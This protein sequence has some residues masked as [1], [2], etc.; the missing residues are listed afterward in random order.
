[1]KKVWIIPL[2]LLFI[3]V[4]A[5]T[6]AQAAVVMT[7]GND[8]QGNFSDAMAV[9]S[10]PNTNY[11]SS[12]NLY[13]DFIDGS[14]LYV[15]LQYFNVTNILG[16]S[17][18]QSNNITNC[19]VIYYKYSDFGSDTSNMTF[20][21][22]NTSWDEG[23]VTW[24]SYNMQN[25]DNDYFANANVRSL[26]YSYDTSDFVSSGSHKIDIK[27][28]VCQSWGEDDAINFGFSAQG[29]YN[30]AGEIGF[31]FRSREY[32]T[33]TLERWGV[34]IT[35]ESTATSAPVIDWTNENLP[36]NY[37]I[38]VTSD[39]Y[40]SF[41]CSDEDSA[42]LSA[43][44]DIDGTFKQSVYGFSQGQNQTL[45]F[46]SG[47]LSEG[48]HTV[49]LTCDDGSDNTTASKNL[50]WDTTPPSLH[51]ESGFP[52]LDNSSIAWNTGNVPMNIT[53]SDD[54]E[55]WS[56]QINITN[57]TGDQI[58]SFYVE[59]LNVS[60]YSYDSSVYG[61]LDLSSNS[62]GTVYTR[63]E[64]WDSHTHKTIKDFKPK[65]HLDTALLEYNTGDN[66]I[67]VYPT[68]K[69]DLTSFG[70]TKKSDRYTFDYEF[71]K[72]K[73]S[74]S[75]ILSSWKPITYQK[76]SKYKGHFVTGTDWVD[77]ELEQATGKE[78]YTITRLDE[79]TY[80]VTV[81]TNKKSLKF[82]SVGKLNQKVE[83]AQFRLGSSPPT[84]PTTQTPA[85]NSNV[86]TG[87]QTITC[88]GSTD[89]DGDT[90]YVQF[91]GDE[92]NDNPS[93]LLQNTTSTSYA[94]S[95][96]PLASYYWKCRAC[97]VNGGCS[98]YTEIIGFNNNNQNIYN[99]TQDGPGTA[100]EGETT[101]FGL[102]FTYNTQRYSAV[103]TKL[104]MGGQNYTA[105][106]GTNLDLTTNYVNAPIAEVSQNTTVEALWFIELTYLNGSKR[107]DTSLGYNISVSNI[108]FSEGCT[109]NTTDALAINFSF[110]DENNLAEF[111]YGANDSKVDLDA[112]FTVYKDNININDTRSF[113]LTNI[114][115][116]QLCIPQGLEL[117]TRGQID[118]V[119]DD[120]DKR[121]FFYYDKT[122][123]NQT[124]N[125]SLYLLE[126]SLATGITFVI[127][128][129]SGTEIADAYIYVDRYD[130][131]TDTYKLVAMGLT[132]EDGEDYIFL[133]KFDVEYRVRIEEA[134][135]Q[136]YIDPNNR[137]ISSSDNTVRIRTSEA[138]LSGVI[139]QFKTISYTLVNDT[140]N[141]IFTY[142]DSSSSASEYCLTVYKANSTNDGFICET[143]LTTNT[144]TITCDISDYDG[145]YIATAWVSINP[146][147]P[148]AQIVIDRIDS[149]WSDTD[150]GKT[151]LFG[152]FLIILTLGCIGAWMGKVSTTI[153]MTLLGVFLC[154]M[155]G[156]MTFG[157][158]NTYVFMGLLACGLALIF[159]SRS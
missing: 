50:Y 149:I 86:T 71:S 52:L 118:Y 131:G 156:F 34:R 108:Y 6:S 106:T 66:V 138:T 62:N 98:A 45:N 99:V 74:Y 145:T 112:T 142:S 135:V 151:G 67:T 92:N 3:F 26:M 10:S 158:A 155:L 2:M 154:M 95:M 18:L 24:N 23:T 148:I 17:I 130:T 11:G 150:F 113:S 19:T 103:T 58:H 140:T 56:F 83:D 133:R 144:G 78:K 125:E 8:T 12:T 88:T 100:I 14:T 124:Q 43:H 35:Y 64:C 79:Y 89:P 90:I 82:K 91:V 141:V 81:K 93:T 117:T 69:K 102:N 75:F 104:N 30:P 84:I 36:N 80:L 115:D 111:T 63:M 40:Y 76:N 134:G 109:G 87:V 114:T 85:N 13:Y 105:T 15:P 9:L 33:S 70:T 129:G 132:D 4:Q 157:T 55:L 137:K 152:A 49:T 25:T 38:N 94:W 139:N 37:E 46:S 59:D 39:L 159:W 27:P 48:V 7:F 22:L 31:N 116:F 1:M 61:T 42:T 47:T 96:S 44:I 119:K 107:L 73:S 28:E 128:D 122:L 120:Y 146:K 72:Q 110:W 16:E 51:I 143:C 65:K 54:T 147:S 136:T 126:I 77:F 153:G 101:N 60:R 21:E 123:N 32:S 29:S 5:M 41:N 68:D 20:L 57:S 127:E 53:C 97:D 121:Q